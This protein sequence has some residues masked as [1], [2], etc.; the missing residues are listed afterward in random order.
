[1]AKFFDQSINGLSDK[2]K[3]LAVEKNKEI[4][5]ENSLSHEIVLV[6]TLS[7]MVKEDKYYKLSEIKKE[8]ADHLEFGD[9]V[10]EKYVG[11][12]LRRLGF[13]QKRRVATGYEY[14]LKVSEVK[15][16]CKRLEISVDSEGS[17]LSEY[18][19][20]EGNQNTSG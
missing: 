13:T 5:R 16:W 6:K 19:E 9:W 10:N 20:E 4:Q 15:E 1:L 7:S 11:K 2:M 17:E 8:M 18:T 12:I 3:S 14:F